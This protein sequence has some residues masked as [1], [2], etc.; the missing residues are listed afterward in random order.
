MICTIGSCVN[1][2]GK[3]DR[4]KDIVVPV[5]IAV[6]VASIALTICALV[7][8]FIFRHKRSPSVVEGISINLICRETYFNKGKEKK[9]YN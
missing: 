2:D 5:T 8:F 7:L 6:V 4:T 1:K 9:I 3:R